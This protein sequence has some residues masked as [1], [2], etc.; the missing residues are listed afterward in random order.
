MGSSARRSRPD[1]NLVGTFGWMTVWLLGPVT[2]PRVIKSE[3]GPGS[4]EVAAWAAG[5]SDHAT[6]AGVRRVTGAAPT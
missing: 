1:W 3:Y 2:F 4:R 5:L 6:L